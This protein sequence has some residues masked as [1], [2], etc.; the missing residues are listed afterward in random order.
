MPKT[1]K[2]V[3][4]AFIDP[5]LES[6]MVSPCCGGETKG[7]CQDA[8]VSDENR[9][10][11][12]DGYVFASFFNNVEYCRTCKRILKRFWNDVEFQNDKERLIFKKLL[13]KLN[14]PE[15]F[16]T[17]RAM[18]SDVEEIDRVADREK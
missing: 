10:V 8:H 5:R 2:L 11:E 13:A 17:K 15:S 4:L 18:F 6:S 1:F 7:F 9:R 16:L 14:M 12:V 3:N